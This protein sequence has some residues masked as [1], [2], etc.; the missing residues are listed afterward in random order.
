M[1][2]VRLIVV[3]HSSTNINVLDVDSIT[4]DSWITSIQPTLHYTINKGRLVFGNNLVEKNLVVQFDQ[5]EGHYSLTRVI[6]LKL[7]CQY[8]FLGIK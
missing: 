3:A 8:V 2:Q 5:A 1:N 4:G 7:M 6:T